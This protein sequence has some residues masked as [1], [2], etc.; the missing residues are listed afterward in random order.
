MR[1]DDHFPHSHTD[2]WA[3]GRVGCAAPS[4]LH[5]SPQRIP[6]SLQ[7]AQDT[8]ILAPAGQSATG[9][10]H[11]SQGWELRPPDSPAA[12]GQMQGHPAGGASQLSRGLG[13]SAA[14]PQ[15]AA[16]GRRLPSRHRGPHDQHPVHPLHS[17]ADL[18]A[19][20]TDGNMPYDVRDRTGHWTAWRQPW[21]AVVSAPLPPARGGEAALGETSPG[22]P[23]G[24]TQDS[25]EQAG[26]CR[27]AC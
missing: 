27:A 22:A 21:P 2:A 6:R 19:V 12:Q 9:H 23:A 25:I 11:R 8:Q 7:S 1:V 5:S 20:N 16:R 18:L 3:W 15:C 24:I 26:P 14:A 4:P 10:I 17:G 13:P